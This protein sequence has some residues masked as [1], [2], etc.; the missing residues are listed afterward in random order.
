MFSELGYERSSVDQIAERAG[1][2]KAT[3]YNHF[4]DKKALFVAAFSGEADALREEV[5]CMLHREPVGAV[6]PALQA[7]G[8]RLLALVLAPA[9]VAV[10]RHAA[11]EVARFPELGQMLFDRGPG[12]MYP[13]IADYLRRW[14]DR[15]ALRLDDPHT[16]AIH[17]V[18]LCHGDLVVRSQLGVLPDP[19]EPAITLTVQRAVSMFLAAHAA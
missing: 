13:V 2:S 1:V 6:A 19:L 8:E 15:G 14:H 5:R 17:F 9:T 4:R 11:A 7:V 10:D 18:L 16:A 3:L 12:A